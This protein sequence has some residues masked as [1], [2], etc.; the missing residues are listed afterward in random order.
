MPDDPL[1]IDLQ[2]L[3][4]CTKA[5]EEEFNEFVETANKWLYYAPNKAASLKL[6]SS[7]ALSCLNK[8]M[9]T[10][11]SQVGKVKMNANYTIS[12]S[13]ASSIFMTSMVLVGLSI[14]FVL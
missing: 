9:T 1:L 5:N 7:F 4:Q 2:S 14:I 3:K 10:G 13:Q 8:I 6:Q 12:L 11:A